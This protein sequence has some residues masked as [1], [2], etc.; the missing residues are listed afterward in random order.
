[1]K[2][3]GTYSVRLA[4]LCLAAELVLLLNCG[5][6]E[7]RFVTDCRDAALRLANN[8]QECWTTKDIHYNHL[9]HGCYLSLESAEVDTMPNGTRLYSQTQ[10]VMDVNENRNILSCASTRE[11]GQLMEQWLCSGPDSQTISHERFVELRKRYLERK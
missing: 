10:Q 1:M 2:N 11:R 8:Y 7:Q 5:R 9:D 6:T 4:I 3:L